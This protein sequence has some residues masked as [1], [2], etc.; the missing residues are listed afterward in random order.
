M[1]LAGVPLY[2]LHQI[3]RWE[4]FPALP[5][6]LYVVN[7][8][9]GFLSRAPVALVGDGLAIIER[10]L[11]KGEAIPPNTYPGNYLLGELV[12]LLAETIL[13]KDWPPQSREA[14]A[15]ASA[16]DPKKMEGT[17][18]EATLEAVRRASRL[19][20]AGRDAT[21]WEVLDISVEKLLE[22]V[23]VWVYASDLGMP[24][25]L[26]SKAPKDLGKLISDSYGILVRKVATGEPLWMGGVYENLDRED[27]ELLTEG[28]LRSMLAQLVPQL[29]KALFGV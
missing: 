25:S 9:E 10:A 18:S 17:P 24:T 20:G 15:V 3:E 13:K 21:I 11:A 8:A 7:R 16:V 28:I 2:Y 12:A 26:N 27:A 19:I 1:P 4:G 29:E 14:L 5:S 6:P 23:P 22:G